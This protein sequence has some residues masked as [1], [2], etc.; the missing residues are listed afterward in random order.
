MISS[1]LAQQPRGSSGR[2]SKWAYFGP[3]WSHAL[4]PLQRLR[5]R[6]EELRGTRRQTSKEMSMIQ[7]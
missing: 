1:R 4:A 6:T 3:P 2:S 5:R 7:K